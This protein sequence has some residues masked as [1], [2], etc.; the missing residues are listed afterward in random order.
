MVIAVRDKD[1]RKIIKYI[2][3]FVSLIWTERYQEHGDFELTVPITK[4]NVEYLVEDNYLTIPTSSAPMVIDT[5]EISLKDSNLKVSGKSLFSLLNR[6]IQW[7][8][9]NVKTKQITAIDYLV[10]H[11]FRPLYYI[12]LDSKKKATVDDKNR[13]VPYIL[14]MNS[15]RYPDDEATIEQ[16]IS[17]GDNLYETVETFLASGI[18]LGFKGGFVT[19]EYK[20]VNIKFEVYRGDDRSN[21]IFSEQMFNLTDAKLTVS[22]SDMKTSIL[23]AGD[24]TDA[25]RRKVTVTRYD[26]VKTEEGSTNQIK[27]TGIFRREMFA[28]ARDLQKGS[29]ESL[30]EYKKRLKDRGV[31]KISEK[32]KSYVADGE[33]FDNGRY[34]IGVDYSLGDLVTLKSKYFTAKARIYE[35]IQSW[36]GG[37][38]QIYPTFQIEEVDKKEI[39]ESYNLS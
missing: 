11:D 33:I 27:Y 14:L 26:T 2:T 12:S 35:V 8:A 39:E 3:L 22:T 32:N 20:N 19:D 10:N 31:E 9:Y 29:N 4:E 17:M 13:D 37:E 34:K 15:K 7:E 30:A 1:T 25:K 36:E 18:Q 16:T 28:D 24:G 5:V 38:Y 21:I 23:V 6:R